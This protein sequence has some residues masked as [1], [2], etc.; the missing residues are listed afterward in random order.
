MPDLMPPDVIA[1][2]I[3]R[4]KAVLPPSPAVVVTDEF[5]LNGAHPTKRL[6]V[7]QANGSDLDPRF[8]SQYDVTLDVWGP[9]RKESLTMAT[10]I[11]QGFTTRGGFRLDVNGVVVSAACNLRPARVPS[12]EVTETFVRH[13]ARIDMFVRSTSAT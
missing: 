11:C 13:I 9:S 6:V 12:G 7:V 10:T 4:V 8:T 5:P 1:G 2:L 3:A